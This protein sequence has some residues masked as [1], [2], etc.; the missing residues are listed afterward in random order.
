AGDTVSVAGGV[1]QD[2]M[3]FIVE[4]VDDQMFRI[5]VTS[6][7]SS[8]A[9]SSMALAVRDGDSTWVF[10]DGEVVM[11]EL[12][13]SRRRSV[14]SSSSAHEVLTTPMPATVVRL[15]VAPRD[16]VTKNMPLVILEA[17]KMELPLRAPRDGVVRRVMCREGELVQ[18]GPPLVEL[19]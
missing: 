7:D 18:P 10:V 8:S 15:C 12:Q 17:M 13:T 2:V 1:D 3:R 5:T 4:A 11:L 9:R 6:D 14:R 19:E 16:R